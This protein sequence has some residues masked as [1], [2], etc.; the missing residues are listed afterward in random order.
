MFFVKIHL[1]SGL[2][3]DPKRSFSEDTKWDECWKSILSAY[4]L[5]CNFDDDPALPLR[6]GM[7][8]SLPI[9]ILFGCDEGLKLLPVG[10]LTGFVLVPCNNP[11]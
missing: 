3:E 10:M 8:V 4:E 11:K 7:N 1:K 6:F 9:N 5:L 2:I